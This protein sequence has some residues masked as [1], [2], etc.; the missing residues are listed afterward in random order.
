M[1]V[2]DDSEKGAEE[3]EAVEE[4]HYE[5]GTEEGPVHPVSRQPAP[6]IGVLWGGELL[7][8]ISDTKS[9]L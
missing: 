2:S 3:D 6:V 8:H 7:K 4:E 5:E 1:F 9:L